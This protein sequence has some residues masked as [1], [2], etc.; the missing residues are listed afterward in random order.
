MPFFIAESDLAGLI[1]SGT[2]V[3]LSPGPTFVDYPEKFA[4][5]IRFSKDGNPIIQSPL[6]DSRPRQWIWTRYRDSVKGY[7]SL[8]NQL[9]NYQY[10]LRTKFFPCQKSLGIC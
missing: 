5:E 2:I 9:L 10:K 6:K 8:Y 7:I 3:Q 1:V 4:N